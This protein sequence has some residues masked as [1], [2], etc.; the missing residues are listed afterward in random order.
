[1]ATIRTSE[2]LTQ[3]DLY[4]RKQLSDKFKIT[5]ATL[6]TG[7]FQPKGHAS[8]WLFVTRKK[9]ANRT[10]YVDA[11]VGDTLHWQGQISGRTDQLIIDHEKRGLELLVF[12][13][14]DAR[15][16]FRYEGVFEYV[17]HSGGKPTSFKL[18]RTG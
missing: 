15:A 14:E 1:M 10:Q 9:P 5:D 8:I 17:E 16:P 4:S 13:R 6:N 2:K 7:V 3:G 18:Q 12:Y 11:L